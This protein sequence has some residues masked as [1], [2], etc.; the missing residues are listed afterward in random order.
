MIYHK[1]V[2]GPHLEQ[3]SCYLSAYSFFLLNCSQS[4]MHI[5]ISRKFSDST[6]VEWALDITPFYKQP[7][8]VVKNSQVLM[9]FECLHS[10]FYWNPPLKEALETLPPPPPLPAHPF[11]VAPLLPYL[12]S[13]LLLSFSSHFYS[14]FSSFKER[15]SKSQRQWANGGATSITWGFKSQLRDFLLSYVPGKAL[16]FQEDLGKL[17]A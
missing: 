16:P 4:W 6:A 14:S 12:L 9:D 11:I 8:V 1:Q 5:G 17:S 13:R 10:S 7:T 15:E 2:H 3:H